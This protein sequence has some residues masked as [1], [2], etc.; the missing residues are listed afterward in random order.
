MK[1]I[2]LYTSFLAAGFADVGVF[3]T[4]NNYIQLILA[5]I[6]YFPLIYIAFKIF[7]RRT[8]PAEQIPL[9][10]PS[11]IEPYVS[12]DNKIEQHP[13]SQPPSTDE[14][15][16][17]DINKRV[18]LKIIGATGLSFFIS[19][20]FS[21]KIESHILGRPEESSTIS[22]IDP[23]G[24]VIDPAKHNPMDNYKISEV[25]YGI[26][27][28]YGFIDQNDGWFI[29]KEDIN[30]GT[31]RYRK[32][33]GNFPDNWNNRENLKYDYYNQVFTK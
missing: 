12:I 30:S 3:L 4:S 2:A 24:N 17:S 22:I 7:P 14:V 1:K 28:Y 15:K 31:Y 13:I 25:D 10:K 9:Q 27:T 26:N 23:V 19:S 11:I 6:L 5:I 29:M 32:G 20:L 16:I 33:I 8:L 18:F 21:K